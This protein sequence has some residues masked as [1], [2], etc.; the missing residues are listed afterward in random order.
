MK[1]LL[2][3]SFLIFSQM[4]FSRWG[5]KECMKQ[6]Y[7]KGLFKEYKYLP[8][9]FGTFKESE[10]SGWTTD[11]TTASTDPVISSKVWVGQTQSYSSWGK[12]A[13]IGMTLHKA[14]E[15]YIAQN[16]DEIL[17]EIA[18]GKGEHLKALAFFSACSK[19]S[20]SSF[21]GSLQKEI[22][23]FVEL[24]SKD[25][26]KFSSQIDQVINSQENLRKSCSLRA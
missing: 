3:L 2:L 25:H 15:N 6:M 24:D 18:I 23:Q 21:S 11:G 5:D 16:K 26:V 12:C 22:D 4:T 19:E 13:F 14:R 17:R 10:S 20:L 8:K 1:S 9:G 7:S